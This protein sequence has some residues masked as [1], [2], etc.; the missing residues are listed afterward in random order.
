M[1]QRK[2]SKRNQQSRGM[3]KLTTVRIPE[4]CLVFPDRYDFWGKIC[5]DTFIPTSLSV[6]TYATT[7]ALNQPIYGFGPQVNYAGSFG[8]NTFAG[9]GC[10][11]SSPGA[12]GA[13]SPY[14]YV[15][16]YEVDITY[17]VVNLG[18]VPI[19][20]SIIPSNQPSLLGMSVNTLPEQRGAVQHLVNPA[21]GNK[22]TNIHCRWSLGDIYGITTKEFLSDRQYGQNVGNASYYPV[23]C[24]VVTTAFDGVSVIDVIY[25]QIYKVHCVASDMNNYRSVVPTYSSLGKDEISDTPVLVSGD[26]KIEVLPDKIEPSTS[27]SY[28]GFLRSPPPSQ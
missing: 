11:F 8:A 2:H 21:S 28:F 22:P 15:N 5:V 27:G 25:K 24:H 16:C 7:Y 26:A 9:S 13:L 12:T 3:R 19:Y 17:E 10:L 23:Y 18:T 20:F 4:A 6:A 1:M 14:N